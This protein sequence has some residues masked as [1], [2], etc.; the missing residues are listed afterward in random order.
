M[1][2][3]ASVSFGCDCSG[4]GHR[5][6]DGGEDLGDGSTEVALAPVTCADPFVNRDDYVNGGLPL[7]TSNEGAGLVLFIDFD[8]GNYRGTTP[9][10]GYYTGTSEERQRIVDSFNYLTQYFAM[11]DL[12]ITTDASKIGAGSSAQNWAWI[13]ISP[14]TSGGTAVL[15][16]IGTPATPLARC[17]TSTITG[18][19]RSRRIAHE[20]GHN[21][22]LAHDGLYEVPGTQD[23]TAGEDL[24]GDACDVTDPLCFF[25]FEDSTGWDTQYGTIMGGGGEG[26]RNGWGLE[27][28]EPSNGGTQD[29]GH[30]QDSMDLI[31]EAVRTLGGSTAN[32]GW[33]IDDH[34]DATPSPLCTSAS[35][36]LYR[37]GVLGRPDDVDVFSLDWPG[38]D[39]AVLGVATDVSAAL[40]R[41]SIYRNGVKVGD[42]SVQGA[43]AGAYEVRVESTGEYGAIGYYRIDVD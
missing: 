10:T 41:I 14:E 40:V 27:L 2:I 43:A 19:D 5:G 29:A 4:G 3:L 24:A 33:A 1:T 7:L 23:L 12:S 30:R 34:P 26:A 17:G 37:Y 13:V 31:R 20:I 42:D 15:D 25:K 28:Y 9:L 36:G 21:F 32:D 11:F 35:E 39:L 8:G 6:P 38:G 22:G 16:A 18:S